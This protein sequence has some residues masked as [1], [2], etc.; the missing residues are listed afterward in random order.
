MPI[1]RK[2]LYFGVMHYS[3]LKKLSEKYGN[4]LVLIYTKYDDHDSS[5]YEDEDSKFA[6]REL[7]Y[8]ILNF[9]ETYFTSK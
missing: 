8:Q 7:H 1:W 3:L 9:A 5:N 2:R 6:M 4:K